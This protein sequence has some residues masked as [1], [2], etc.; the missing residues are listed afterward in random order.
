MQIQR[1]DGVVVDSA[2]GPS[3][4]PGAQAGPAIRDRCGS[5]CTLGTGYPPESNDPEVTMPPPRDPT[6]AAD[7]CRRQPTADADSCRW[8]LTTDP[9]A[10]AG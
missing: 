4:H 10:A 3:Q 7:R 8:W 1:P 6:S 2:R 9:A 5:R